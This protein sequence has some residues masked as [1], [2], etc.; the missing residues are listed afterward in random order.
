MNDTAA[1]VARRF[2][3]MM[4]SRTAEERLV[5]AARMF[6]SAQ[7]LVVAGAGVDQDDAARRRHLFSKF[8]ARD[9]SESDRQRI[10]Q[11]LA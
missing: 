8:Y 4:S 9:F 11:R 1:D 5:M 2:R 10:L 6:T 3:E 7:K